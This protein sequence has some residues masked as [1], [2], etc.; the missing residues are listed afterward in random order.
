MNVMTEPLAFLNGRWLPASQATVNVYDAG[1]V[2]GA[3]V[4]EQLRTF[5]GKLFKLDEHLDRLSR[6]LVTIGGDPGMPWAQLHAAA[7]C[8]V[9]EIFSLLPATSDLGL[10]IF[11]PP[12]AYETLAPAGIADRPTLAMHTYPLPFHM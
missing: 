8:I 1:F 6:S 5:G 3:T 10:S 11:A 2:L 12:G 7:E 4:S 9:T